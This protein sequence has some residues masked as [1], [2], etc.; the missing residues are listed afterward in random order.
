MGKKC[1]MERPRYSPANVFD[2]AI[3]RDALKKMDTSRTREADGE[4]KGKKNLVARRVCR[5]L[6]RLVKKL[7]QRRFISPGGYTEARGTGNFAFFA[8]SGACKM[9]VHVASRDSARL[10]KQTGKRKVAPESVNKK[11]LTEFPPAI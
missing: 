2:I 6:R 8:A 1:I 5:S 11:R 7:P 10:R 3:Y 4:T 9:Y